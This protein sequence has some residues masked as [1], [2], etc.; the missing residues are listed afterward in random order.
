MASTAPVITSAIDSLSQALKLNIIPQHEYL[1]QGSILDSA[2]EHLLHRLKGLCDNVDSGP[3]PFHDH[4]VCFS[5]QAP[6]Q[7]VHLF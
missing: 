4:E 6:N 1:L 3:E 5:L 2:V 7:T